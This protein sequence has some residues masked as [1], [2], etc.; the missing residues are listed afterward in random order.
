M[1]EIPE[2]KT[3]AEQAEASLIGKTIIKV[4]NATTPHKFTWF[5][6]DPNEYEKLLIGKQIKNA[7]GHGMFVDLN[8]DSDTHITIGDGTN[9]RY[10]RPQE[11]LPDKHQLLLVLDDNSFLVFTVAMYGMICAYQGALDNKYHMGSF[12]S[13]SPL[14]D[15]FDKP[16]FENIFRCMKKDISI[17]ALLATEQRIPGFGN[18]VLQDILFN[19]SIN[20]KRKISTIS[21]FEKDELFHNIK[22]ILRNMTD[23]G[24]RDTE[25][26]LFGNVGGYRTV[27]SKNT[28][29]DPCPNCGGTITKEAYL[30]GSVYYCKMCQ[31]LNK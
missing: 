17:K 8:L 14:D 4:M 1:L 15:R 9:L 23:K 12:K 10:Y 20:P 22:Y 16:F 3:I 7:L 11:K 6:G 5:C 29:K 30:G 25:K 21:D 13:I 27:L 18:G 2:T 31:P 24:G 19:S 28:Y 26:D